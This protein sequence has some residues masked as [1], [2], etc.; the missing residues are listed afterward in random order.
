MSMYASILDLP[1]PDGS[2][3]FDVAYHCT[4]DGVRIILDGRTCYPT[5]SE[6]REI[7]AALN[8]AARLADEAAV[9]WQ[10]ARA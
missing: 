8:D 7:A 5:P 2:T 6:A 4:G 10:G 1:E 9:E 3:F